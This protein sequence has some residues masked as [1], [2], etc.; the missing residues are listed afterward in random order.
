MKVRRYMT[1]AGMAAL[2]LTSCVKDDLYDTP[3]PDKGA[4]IIATDWTEALAE[5]TVPETYLLRMDGGEAVQADEKKL[6]YPDLLTP[7]KHTLLAYNEPEGMTVE[8]NIATVQMLDGMLVPL[9]GY[10]FSA[11]KELEI[12]QDDTLRVTVSMK[13]RLCPIV[14]NLSLKGENTES[15]ALIT[16]T[17]SGMA[18][19]VDL[20]TGAVGSEN[21]TVAL[22]V[23][24]AE[25]RTRTYREGQL[26]MRCRV[27]GTDPK[28]RQI[29]T[30]KVTMAD[31][32]VQTIMS[33]LTEYL[34]DLNA[35]MKP[36]ELEGTVEAPQDGHF[37]GTIEKWETV[38]GG[39]IDAN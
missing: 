19:S 28:E 10:L 24:Q 1:M 23:R 5:S 13:R 18:A 9:P 35:D 11:K 34:K 14:L 16:A 12:V 7:G 31:G 39:D 29:L 38:S 2:L 22:D 37:S 20:R 32:Y 36:I 33:D 6:C 27:T 21:A 25:A 15:I 26:E 17:L 4:V 3:H 8:G 30:V